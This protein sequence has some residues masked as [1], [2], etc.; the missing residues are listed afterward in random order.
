MKTEQ[1]IKSALICCETAQIENN[2]KLCPVYPEESILDC[3]NCTC[4]DAWN[5]VLKE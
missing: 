3:L 1:E 5:W 2:S 4:R